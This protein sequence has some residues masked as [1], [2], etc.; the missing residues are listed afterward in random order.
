MAHD[1]SH[2]AAPT[3]ERDFQA[4]C[5]ALDS[6]SPE[7]QSLLLAKLSLILCHE[8]ADTQVVDR[9][10]ARALRDLPGGA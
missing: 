2:A 1:N 7:R 4:I 6:V 9:A 8:V 10:I 5:R 3:V